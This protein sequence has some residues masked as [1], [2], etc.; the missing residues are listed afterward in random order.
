MKKYAC[1]LCDQEFTLS[2]ENADGCLIQIDMTGYTPNIMY[3]FA[4]MEC[5][6]TNQWWERMSAKEYSSM[7]VDG[8]LK[9]PEHTLALVE[10]SK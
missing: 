2:D 8:K 6:A 3:V 9:L 4:G 5:R 10:E 1:M 7:I